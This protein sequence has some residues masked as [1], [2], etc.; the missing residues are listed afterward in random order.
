MLADSAIKTLN[1]EPGSENIEKEYR[2]WKRAVLSVK[3][4][5]PNEPKKFPQKTEIL[6]LA[7]EK[8]DIDSMLE[9]YHHFA[10]KYNEVSRKSTCTKPQLMFQVHDMLFDRKFQKCVAMD[11]GFHE[12]RMKP[13]DDRLSVWIPIMFWKTSF[14]RM[15]VFPIVEHEEIKAAY[16]TQIEAQKRTEV[17]EK[18]VPI[19]I[20]NPVV[21]IRLL[22][23]KKAREGL[24][25]LTEEDWLEAG[26]VYSDAELHDIRQWYC[27]GGNPLG[28]AAA[29]A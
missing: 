1:H 21:L 24:Q 23:D 9:T 2:N 29:A 18:H 20:P 15:L 10:R 3:G 26:I 6:R 16:D 22:I 5:E 14:I 28:Q 25:G 13:E 17:L 7:L 19:Y 8:L 12:T 4:E 27:Y 11:H